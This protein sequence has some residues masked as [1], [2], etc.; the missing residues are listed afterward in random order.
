MSWLP[1]P[2]KDIWWRVESPSDDNDR[3]PEELL[4]QLLPVPF[5]RQSVRADRPGGGMSAA[6][7]VRLVSDSRSRPVPETGSCGAGP[8]TAKGIVHQT[9]QSAGR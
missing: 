2:G 1:E 7:A 4:P 5:H 3:M 6:S 9:V 8:V